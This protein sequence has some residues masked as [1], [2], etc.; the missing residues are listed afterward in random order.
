M[1]RFTVAQTPSSLAYSNSFP[2]KPLSQQVIAEDVEISI[3]DAEKY[4]N[5]NEGQDDDDDENS[6]VIKCVEDKCGVSTINPRLSSVSSVDDGYGRNYRTTG[7]FNATPTASSEASW[8][9]QSGLL[10]HPPGSIA[11]SMR[12]LRLDER[13]KKNKG[14]SGKWFFRRRCPCTGKNSV[15]VEEKRCSDQPKSNSNISCNGSLKPSM[16]K[17]SCETEEV[18]G[19]LDKASN[20]KAKEFVKQSL[21]IEVGRT[22]IIN[23]VPAISKEDEEVV[24]ACDN[25]EDRYSPEKHFP[26]AATAQIGNHRVVPSGRS[27]GDSGGFS[28]PILNPPQPQS[29]GKLLPGIGKQVIS[30]NSKGFDEPPRESLEVFQPLDESPV[31]GKS[32][33]PRGLMSLR[34]EINHR[35]SFNFL[36]S[37][38]VRKS[39]DGDDDGDVMS[40]ASSDLFEIESF[41]TQSTMYPMYRRK[42]SLDDMSSYDGRRFMGRRSLDETTTIATPSIAATECY[43]PSEAS[44]DW[45]VTTAE[46]FSVA[47]LS[48]SASEYQDFQTDHSKKIVAINSARRRGNG[49]LLTSCRC[50]KAVNVAPRQVKYVPDQQQHHHHHN[51]SCANAPLF[52]AEASRIQAASRLGSMHVTRSNSARMFRALTTH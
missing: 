49:G 20:E 45:S 25:S 35:S 26:T 13:R 19:V 37:P 29:V 36:T 11:V 48:V 22:K 21:G 7:S 42:D 38:T 30:S 3:F 50:E 34:E 33:E 31:Q 18:V 47:N 40:D 17:Q 44:I 23:L 1:E 14:S 6:K 32:M 52:P 2:P 39:N 43:E 10:S 24:L 46:G 9:S 12:T 16:I 28:F 15:Q 4:F 51:R 5:E 27:F 41:S 8:N